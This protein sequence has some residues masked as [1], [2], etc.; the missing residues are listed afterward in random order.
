MLLLRS[1]R[2]FLLF[3]LVL[4]V[5]LGGAVGWAYSVIVR[6]GP[7]LTERVLVIP[8]GVGVRQ[9]ADILERQKIVESAFLFRLAVRTTERGKILQ[10]G[11]YAF[12]AQISMRETIALLDSG[13]TVVRRLTIAEGLTSQQVLTQLANTDGLTGP[14]VS[15]PGEGELLPETYHF[16]HGDGRGQLVGRMRIQMTVALEKAWAARAP[17]LPLRNPTELLVLASIVEKE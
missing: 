15:T 13:K 16:S 4:V 1:I 5:G 10:A 11:E 3:L 8:R 12:A 17:D 2:W 6:P 9:I 7:S 14:I